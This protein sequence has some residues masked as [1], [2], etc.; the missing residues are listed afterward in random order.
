MNDVVFVHEPSGP[1]LGSFGAVGFWSSVL[2]ET[3]I[4][5]VYAR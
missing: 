3:L 4:S 1:E 5:S 2:G